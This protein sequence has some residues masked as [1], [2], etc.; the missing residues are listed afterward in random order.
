MVISLNNMK[1]IY[2]IVDKEI[3]LAVIVPSRDFNKPRTEIVPPSEF[4]QGAA[5]RVNDGDVFRPHKH[6]WKSFNSPRIKT[7]EAWLVSRGTIKIVIFDIDDKIIHTSILRN[8]DACFTIHGGHT[9]ECI[10]DHTCL[11]EIKNGPYEGQAKDKVF[12]K[13]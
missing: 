9:Y 12:I 11:W 5:I 8:G 3:L 4:L 6:I 2:S 1:N 10:E 13:E 7:Q